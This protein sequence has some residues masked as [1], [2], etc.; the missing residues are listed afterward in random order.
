[1]LLPEEETIKTSPAIIVATHVAH[2]WHAPFEGCQRDAYD[3]V[4]DGLNRYP[5]AVVALGSCG[6]TGFRQATLGSNTSDILRF[7]DGDILVVNTKDA[8]GL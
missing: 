8:P 3:A 2:V 7:L 5:D 1:M 6:N 4:K